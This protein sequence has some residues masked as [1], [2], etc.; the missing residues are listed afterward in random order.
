MGGQTHRDTSQMHRPRPRY[1]HKQGHTETPQHQMRRLN[2]MVRARYNNNSKYET[3]RL[4]QHAV[5]KHRAENKRV[6][7]REN[8]KRENRKQKKKRQKRQKME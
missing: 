1:P 2:T 6:V 7:R 3:Y 8:R 5:D 4:D